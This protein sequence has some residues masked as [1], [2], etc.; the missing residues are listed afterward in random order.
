MKLDR[1]CSP[2]GIVTVACKVYEARM[3]LW[4]DTSAPDIMAQERTGRVFPS[5][6]P[7]L[8]ASLIPGACYAGYHR[9]SGTQPDFFPKASFGK[10][11]WILIMCGNT[12]TNC[13]RG[14]KK[15]ARRCQIEG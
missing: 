8:L 10:I 14:R 1:L 13:P 11:G 7:F 9:Y 5:R 6:A 4:A 15:L 3:A 2:S 12:A